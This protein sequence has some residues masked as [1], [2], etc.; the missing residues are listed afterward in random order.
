MTLIAVYTG[1]NKIK[2]KCFHIATQTQSQQIYTF[3]IES[4][5]MNWKMTGFFAQLNA[6]T[7]TEQFI[8]I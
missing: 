1:L 8:S 7:A 5:Q 4:K 6:L 2:I 3:Y